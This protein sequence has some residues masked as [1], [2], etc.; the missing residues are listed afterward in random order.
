MTYEKRFRLSVVIR[1]VGAEPLTGIDAEVAQRRLQVY[2]DYAR[3]KFA[4]IP[5]SDEPIEI[6][7]EPADPRLS[8]SERIDSI[9]RAL[10]RKG[11]DV[12]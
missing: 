5:A 6:I 8:V 3:D 11:F 12:S 10:E 7:V 2:L 9:I 1:Y 4:E